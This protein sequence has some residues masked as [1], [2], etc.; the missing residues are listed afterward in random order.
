M[1]DIIEDLRSRTRGGNVPSWAQRAAD[2]IERLRRELD[3]ARN[4]EREQIACFLTAIGHHDIASQ[5]FAA[6]T[7]PVNQERRNAAHDAA[8]QSQG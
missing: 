8:R 7:R 4:D 2:E 6:M 3:E 5:V 1:T